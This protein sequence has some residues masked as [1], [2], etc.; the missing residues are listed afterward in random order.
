MDSEKGPKFKINRENVKPRE[1]WRVRGDKEKL[2]SPR[3]L[4]NYQ[5]R[6]FKFDVVAAVEEDERKVQVIAEVVEVRSGRAQRTE[7]IQDEILGRVVFK[8]KTSYGKE[9]TIFFDPDSWDK[10]PVFKSFVEFDRM[11]GEK[12]T[13]VRF[14]EG[15]L[16]RKLIEEIEANS[17]RQRVLPE[18][19]EKMRQV[20]K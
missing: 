10:V 4:K 5:K 16:K 17:T 13:K 12:S 19:H 14:S 3:R 7:F 11:K 20:T 2:V 18:F 1:L 15:E 6:H 8:I 9:L